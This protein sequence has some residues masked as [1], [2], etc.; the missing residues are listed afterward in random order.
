MPLKSVVE[1]KLHLTSCLVRVPLESV[2]KSKLHF[3]E[4]YS[5]N[6][7][8]SDSQLYGLTLELSFSELKQQ[9]QKCPLV[10]LSSF[11]KH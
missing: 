1:S 6:S 10:V 5:H 11:E 2:V 8:D 7:D 3:S 9:R 4:K